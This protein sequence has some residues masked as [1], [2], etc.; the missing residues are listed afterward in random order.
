MYMC[1]LLL[2]MRDQVH[3]LNV[4]DNYRMISLQTAHL[5]KQLNPNQ[6]TKKC[7]NKA[8]PQIVANIWRRNQTFVDSP[9]PAADSPRARREI[10]SQRNAARDRPDN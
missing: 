9:S 8:I 3:P 4:H 1:H 10:E 5:I 6:S 7:I 2:T